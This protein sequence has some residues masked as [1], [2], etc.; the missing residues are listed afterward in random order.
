MRAIPKGQA[1]FIAR[2]LRREK[3][4]NDICGAKASG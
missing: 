1:P 2:P 4:K 3:T